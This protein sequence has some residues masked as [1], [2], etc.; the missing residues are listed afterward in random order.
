MSDFTEYTKLLGPEN[1]ETAF[2]PNFLNDIDLLYS[3]SSQEFAIKGVP[4]IENMIY[5]VCYTNIG[6]REFEPTFG[7]NVLILIHEQ[8]TQTNLMVLRMEMF[9]AI[10]E[11]VPYCSLIFKEIITVAYPDNNLIKAYINYVDIFHGLKRG[12]VLNLIK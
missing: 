1:T 12:F 11:W 3:Y 8:L 10:K 9:R 2:P 6:S 4:V 5:N 7:S